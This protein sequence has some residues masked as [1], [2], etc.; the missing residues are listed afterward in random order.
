MGARRAAL[1]ASLAVLLVD[2]TLDPVCMPVCRQAQAVQ[3]LPR[4]AVAQV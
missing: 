3:E 1:S 2:P 4:L